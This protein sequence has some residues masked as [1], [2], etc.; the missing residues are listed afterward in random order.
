MGVCLGASGRLVPATKPDGLLKAGSLGGPE[1]PNC[2]VLVGV[3]GLCGA[4]PALGAEA[5][6]C[7]AVPALR[8]VLLGPL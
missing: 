1:G 7:G 6:P 8:V 4:V 2:A 5:G 3:V